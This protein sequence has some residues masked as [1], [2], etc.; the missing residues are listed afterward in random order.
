MAAVCTAKIRVTKAPR[1][2]PTPNSPGK[3][4]MDADRQ[5]QFRAA[6]DPVQ[7]R[8]QIAD[9]WRVRDKRERTFEKTRKVLLHLQTAANVGSVKYT[10]DAPLISKSAIPP[11]KYIVMPD[12]CRDATRIKQFLSEFASS[13]SS[14]SLGMT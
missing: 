10:V 12:A 3:Y 8:K 14:A 5:E 2:V 6:S 4:V 9:Q 7:F 11:N 1:H 13:S